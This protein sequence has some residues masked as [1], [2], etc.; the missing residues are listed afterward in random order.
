LDASQKIPSTPLLPAQQAED[1][2]REIVEGSFFRRLRPE[3]ETAFPRKAG[4]DELISKGSVSTLASVGHAS[5]RL[6]GS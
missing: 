3:D 6:L 4:P 1:R 5:R 2:P